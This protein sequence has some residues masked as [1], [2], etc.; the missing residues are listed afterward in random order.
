MK[1]KILK[2]NNFKD[3]YNLQSNIPSIKGINA[4]IQTKSIEHMLHDQNNCLKLA[5]TYFP[6]RKVKSRYTDLDKYQ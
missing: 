2:L 6:V 3:Q 4:D 1:I 5:K